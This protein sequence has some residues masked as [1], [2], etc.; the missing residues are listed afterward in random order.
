MSWL[1]GITFGL[2]MWG[3]WGSLIF[4]IAMLAVVMFIEFR[5]GHWK[6]IRI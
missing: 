3:V 1:A 4:Y 2:G 5:R 6:H